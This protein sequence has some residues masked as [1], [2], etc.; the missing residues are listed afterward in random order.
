MFKSKERWQEQVLRRT[1]IVL[2]YS[3]LKGGLS[4]FRQ[5]RIAY[6]E[7][8]GRDISTGKKIPQNLGVHCPQNHCVFPYVSIPNF[9]IQFIPNQ[10]LRFNG[11]HPVRLGIQFVLLFS[12][13][14]DETLGLVLRI[15]AL[16]LQY[17]RIVSML[18]IEVLRSLMKSLSWEFEA[19]NSS[20]LPHFLQCHQE[21]QANL[22]ILI[23][24][25]KNV[26]RYKIHSNS[27]PC[28][29]L[30]FD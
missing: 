23:T 3:N 12:H 26:V 28:L 14:Q 6:S 27:E 8:V 7:N 21:H 25:E 24:L 1:S 22:I 19:L 10:C 15:S 2:Q 9:L 13:L 30:V 5:S 29:L 16:C 18:D 4:F 11:R 17:I 20:F